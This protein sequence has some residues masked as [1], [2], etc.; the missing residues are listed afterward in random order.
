MFVARAH[1]LPPRGAALALIAPTREV[2]DAAVLRLEKSGYPLCFALLL[3]P[4]AGAVLEALRAAAAEADCGW[5]AG[6]ACATS[7][8]LWAASPLIMEAAP[9]IEVRMG[10]RLCPA[11]GRFTVDSLTTELRVTYNMTADM[12]YLTGKPHV[13][14]Q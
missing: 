9:I 8:R 13:I 11:R 14:C 10:P 4:A 1:E 6:R 12:S 2:L 5:E 3:P 7:R